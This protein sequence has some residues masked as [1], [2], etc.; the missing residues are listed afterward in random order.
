MFTNPHIE[1]EM[2]AGERG[3]YTLLLPE[4]RKATIFDAG[5]AYI[6]RGADS[7]DGGQAFHLKADSDSGR[8]RTAF[9]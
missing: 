3:P 8:T 9:R 2:L 1:N 5:M 7:G 4:G 6:A